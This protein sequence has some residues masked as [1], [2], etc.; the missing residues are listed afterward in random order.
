MSNPVFVR[1]SYDG[2]TRSVQYETADGRILVRSG[3]KLCWRTNNCGNMSSPVSESTGEPAPKKTK[4]F[5]GFA[6]VN[7]P[8][9]HF[10]FIFPSYEEGR[11]QLK[12]S[13]QR[14]YAS[15]SLSDTLDKYAPKGENNTARYLTFV[16]EKTGLSPGDEISALTAAQLETLMDA[17]EEMEG[18]HADKGTRKE[19]WITVSRLTTSEGAAPIGGAQVHVEYGG[20]TFPV[21]SNQ[22]GQLPALPHPAKGAPPTKVKVYKP[23][24]SWKTLLELGHA[25]PPRT[26]VLVLD[27]LVMAARTLGHTAPKGA[28]SQKIPMHYRVKPGDDLAK[29]ASKFRTTAAEIQKL[30]H[31]RNEV[32]HPEQMLWIYAVG[33]EVKAQDVRAAAKQSAQAS[34]NAKAAKARTEQEK[35]KTE[36]PEAAKPEKA[37]AASK[38]ESPS[39]LEQ[40]ATWLS[41][42]PV[43]Y[44]RSKEGD[45]AP[46]ALFD[47]GDKR[48]PWMQV[49]VEEAKTWAGKKEGDIQ[50]THNIFELIGQK[51]YKM[52]TTPWCAAFINYC[53]LKSTPSYPMANNVS[54]SFSFEES[55]S[56]FVEIKKPIYGA[57]RF[58]RRDGGGHVCFVIGM[59]GKELVVLGGNQDDRIKIEY[60]DPN[61]KESQRFFVPIAYSEFAKK[62]Q[63]KELEQIDIAAFKD[64]FSDALAKGLKAS[65]SR[66]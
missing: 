36:R 51:T 46:L 20:K 4:N 64:Y 13:L 32:V 24:G 12:A 19:E 25:S 55:K 27:M 53:L 16:C 59:H 5:I 58:S 60:P 52:T 54:G 34:I 33:T 47:P 29:I 42:T 38:K 17:I 14:K 15:K 65:T 62:E 23:D 63:E 21:H 45:G 18:Y 48:A 39:Y 28:K 3:G 26:G 2:P 66:A 44:A 1:A 49:A 56:K 31:L 50:K 8:E 41:P 7:N 61:T 37:A 57:I 6:Q 35:P 43:Q 22:Q 11:E 40:L 30:N 10:F 9:Q